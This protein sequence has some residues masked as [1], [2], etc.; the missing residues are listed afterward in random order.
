M[1]IVMKEIFFKILSMVKGGYNLAMEIFLLA[2]LKM[3]LCK[4][5]ESYSKLIKLK[6][7]FG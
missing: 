2:I 5:K 3:I 7:E 1:E 4:V 6:K